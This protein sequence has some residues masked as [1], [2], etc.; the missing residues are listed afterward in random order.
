MRSKLFAERR[1][2]SRVPIFIVMTP[3]MNKDVY[4]RSVFSTELSL[5]GD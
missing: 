5:W 3:S 1:S 2:G 4:A